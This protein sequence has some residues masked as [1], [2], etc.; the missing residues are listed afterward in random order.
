[1]IRVERLWRRGGDFTPTR[2][3]KLCVKREAAT[4]KQEQVHIF[5]LTHVHLRSCRQFPDFLPFRPIPA[6]SLTLYTVRHSNLQSKLS[7]ACS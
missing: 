7:V 6:F 1:M 4:A 3:R 2:S 5:M